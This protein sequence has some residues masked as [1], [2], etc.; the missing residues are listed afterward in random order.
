MVKKPEAATVDR[1]YLTLSTAVKCIFFIRLNCYQQ[2]HTVIK[3]FFIDSSV[4]IKVQMS[5]RA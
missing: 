1:L 4:S 3:E 2:Y 5:L